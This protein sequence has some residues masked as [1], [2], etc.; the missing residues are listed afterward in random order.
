MTETAPKILL[1][2][3]QPLTLLGMKMSLQ[4]LN[5]YDVAGEA[6]TGE[7]AII[8]AR[9]IRP[10]VILMDVS[11]PQM[12]GI[13]ASWRIKQEL[14]RTRI[15]MFTSHNTSDV[16]AAALGAGADAYCL[17]S[18][19]VEHVAAII[20]MVMQGK[21][22]ID[23]LVADTVV[24]DH[25]SGRANPNIQLKNFEMQV[26]KLIRDGL[27]AQQIAQQ[28]KSSEDAVAA[29]MRGIIQA[30]SYESAHQQE[31]VNVPVVESAEQW[32]TASDPTQ[33]SRR[34]FADKYAIESV[35]GT[36]GMGTV[37]K[38]EHI[39]MKRQVAL[40]VLHPSLLSDKKAIREF[41]QEGMSIA[42]LNHEGIIGIYDFGVSLS[43]EPYI[44]MELCEGITLDDVLKIE[45]RLALSRFKFLFLQV[46]DALVAAHSAG[47]I[48]CDIKPSNFLI[49]KAADGSEVVK[50]ADFGVAKIMSR[51]SGET[52]VQGEKLLV[53]GTPCYM[54]PEQ[55]SARPLDPRTDIY[56]LG[57]V[58]F[59]ALTGQK[60]FAGNNITEIFTKH[61]HE[62]PPPL[63]SVIPVLFPTDIEDCIAKMMEKEVQNRYQSMTEVREVVA[64]MRD[65][66]F[67]F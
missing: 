23:P 58:M 36:G 56:S 24:R 34:L 39:Y 2:E 50:L 31:T 3:D 59:E 54:S 22:W 53:S 60:A 43:H 67:V 28:L 6:A 45:T 37:Y 65:A 21:V 19:P 44:V 1:V 32:L 9:R 41:Q 64:S 48:H 25:G 42:C 40:K 5:K 26:L 4:G 30:F 66:Q 51:D 57:C 29:V 33:E 35:L 16:V 47:V 10:D 8:E 62:I 11:L 12:D 14:P 52:G 20:D 7:D 13:E 18:R 27:S 55:C 17:K 49:V 38:A 15:V 63:S 61:F 46:C